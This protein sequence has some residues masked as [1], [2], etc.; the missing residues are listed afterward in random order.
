M[1]YRK[2]PVALNGLINLRL[3]IDTNIKCALVWLWSYLLSNTKATLE[4][5][6]MKKLS[7]AETELVIKYV[8]YKSA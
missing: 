7:N 5:Q 6:F 2:R 8:A 3:H 4:A 1:Q